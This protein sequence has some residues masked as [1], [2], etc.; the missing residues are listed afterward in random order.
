MYTRI[1]DGRHKN[2]I[3]S[4]LFIGSI[5]V[6]CFQTPLMNIIP[7]IRYWDEFFAIISIMMFFV[8]SIRNKMP[9]NKDVKYIVLFAC[10]GLISTCIYSYQDF[11]KVALPDMFLCCKFWMVY[12]C[13][14]YVYGRSWNIE[15]NSKKLYKHVTIIIL[16]LFTIFLL[17]ILLDIFPTVSYRFGLKAIT[18][19]YNF[20]TN[21]VAVCSFLLC[22]LFLVGFNNHRWK[23]LVFMLL[24]MIALTLR[25][26]A[27]V[28]IICFFL[29]YYIIIF[30]RKKLTIKWLIPLASI[31]LV[32]SWTQIQYYYVTVREV[33]AR[34]M[35]AQSAFEI[36]KIHFPIGAGYG[37]FGSAYSVKPYSP[38]YV[39]YGMNLIYGLTKENPIFVSD[40]FWPMILGQTGVVGV[41][42]YICMLYKVYQKINCLRF[43]KNYYLAAF[44]AFAYLL[45]SSTSEAAFVS[46]NS[47][48]FAMLLGYLVSLKD[49]S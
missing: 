22:L 31:A 13:S 46:P 49:N 3:R 34:Y 40:S 39:K 1:K 44:F 18:L 15:E 42:V 24:L 9:I 41:W 10:V 45:I 17:D 47:I 37:T 48:P 6:F 25:T 21:L 2:E 33:S 30:K 27:Y 36:A 19:F 11:V 35:L 38:L 5:Y 32:V 12:F 29:L 43:N 23:L 20:P 7:I 26:K 16:F 8:C 28:T 4:R 14:K